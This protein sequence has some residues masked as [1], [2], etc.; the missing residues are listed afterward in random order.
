MT[1]RG[2]ALLYEHRPG[3]GW[4]RP[5]E[6][7]RGIHQV[8]DGASGIPRGQF[9]HDI[10]VFVRQVKFPGPDNVRGPGEDGVDTSLFRESGSNY[11]RF[12]WDG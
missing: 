5:E 9:D 11:R 8:H 2:A 6:V 4:Y 1:V 7:S 12:V 3:L 10:P